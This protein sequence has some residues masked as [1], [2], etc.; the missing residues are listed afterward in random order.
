ML[1]TG[2]VMATAYDVQGPEQTV[3]VFDL[4]RAGPAALL[5][6]ADDAGPTIYVELDACILLIPQSGAAT[7][8]QAGPTLVALLA[9][10][11]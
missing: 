11:R 6:T 1:R 3:V 9:K 5:R 2:W 7:L 4:G 8:A 10:Q